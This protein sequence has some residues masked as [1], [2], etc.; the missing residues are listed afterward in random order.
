MYQFDFTVSR[1]RT[2]EP[3]GVQ[4][5]GTGEHPLH[6]AHASAH[7]G[8]RRMRAPSTMQ[9]RET[10]SRAG[11]APG[12]AMVQVLPPALL[13]L[14]LTASPC[15]DGRKSSSSRLSRR[16]RAE[17]QVRAGAA[18]TAPGAV[19]KRPAVYDAVLFDEACASVMPLEVSVPDDNGDAFLGAILG[20][21]SAL[22]RSRFFTEHWN[23]KPLWVRPR[24]G[25]AARSSAIR[26]LLSLADID[27]LIAAHPEQMRNGLGLKF[28][29][30]G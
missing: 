20:R 5:L 10:D 2:R 24:G 16:S 29:M 22:N 4:L 17:Q 27:A 11:I 13:V 12:I 14:V 1:V 18:H 25:A 9:R 3:S 6:T 30:N 26:E 8:R 28:A 15:A 21:V 23:T 19:S 7:T